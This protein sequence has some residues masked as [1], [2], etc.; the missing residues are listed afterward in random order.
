MMQIPDSVRVQQVGS[1]EELMDHIGAAIGEAQ[2]LHN[3]EYHH[4]DGDIDPAGLEAQLR[5]HLPNHTFF[6]TSSHLL[7]SVEGN[8][9]VTLH[10]A[11][12]STPEG[13]WSVVFHPCPDAGHGDLYNL[14]VL[15][16]NTDV[17]REHRTVDQALQ[18][19]RSLEVIPS[20]SPVP[21][22][23]IS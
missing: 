16:P 5:Q 23:E 4:A 15:G 21:P 1:V 18:T 6:D 9:A 2:T 17:G 10:R 14:R 7:R 3:H 12:W 8:Q 22:S 13:M 19:L 20:A 11:M